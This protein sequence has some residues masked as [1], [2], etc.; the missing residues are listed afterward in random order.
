VRDAVKLAWEAGRTSDG[1]VA[2]S[3]VDV[4]LL[5]ADGRIRVDYQFIES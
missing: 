1:E 4:L 3:G 5:D 2:G